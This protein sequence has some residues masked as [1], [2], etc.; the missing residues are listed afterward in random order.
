MAKL[1]VINSFGPMASTLL[2]G[3]VETLGFTNI[4]IR[5]LGLHQYLMGELKLDSNHME[6]RLKQIIQDHSKSGL[7]GGIS[8]ID[9]KNQKP[10]ALTDY[11][12]VYSQIND[13]NANNIQDL[14][15]KCR[16]IYCDAVIYK[17]I[18]TN[19]DWQIELTTDIHRYNHKEL[20]QAY[21]DNFDE[22]KMIHLH[23]PFSG[24]INSLASQ[25]FTH[26]ELKNRIKFFPHM[27]YA[28]Y[29]LYEQ[30]VAQMPGMHIEFDELFDTPIEELSNKIAEFL[31]VPPSTCDLRSAK[32]DMY[33]KIIPYEK[34]F[35]PF[36]DKISFI[37]H[38]SLKYMENVA[39]TG[40]IAK[41]PH[42]LISWLHYLWSLYS[43]KRN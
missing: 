16:N 23:R 11:K 1:L 9:R 17:E 25:A 14:Y 22:V 15:F 31:G 39:E 36:D 41:L 5:K 10:K 24:W 4:P 8:V 43:Y 38:K 37:Q 6:N 2:S 21:R 32:Y 3:L 19:R 20:Y 34:A 27:R 7:S 33:G 29:K 42:N 30:A 18:K 40:G 28:D 26:P 13:I 12:K 35:T